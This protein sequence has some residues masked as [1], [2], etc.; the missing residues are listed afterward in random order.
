[1]CLPLEACAHFTW[2]TAE[3]LVQV[4]S[5]EA[6][7]QSR[8]FVRTGDVCSCSRSSGRAGSEMFL[9]HT[10][11][12]KQEE[13]KSPEPREMSQP[14]LTGYANYAPGRKTWSLFISAAS[15]AA[16]PNG[17]QGRPGGRR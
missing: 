8:Q 15:W 14:S 10:K 1:M 3:L 11:A 13:I 12:Q 17:K 2:Y 9:S 7:P 5:T 4:F 16:L 6:T